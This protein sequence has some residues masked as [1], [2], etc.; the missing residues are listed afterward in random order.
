MKKYRLEEGINS[1]TDPSQSK[2]ENRC[3]APGEARELDLTPAVKKAIKN[4]LL[5]EVK[6][7]AKEENP[8]KK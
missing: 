3:I 1:F 5:L 2:E 4:K 6:E 7:E 8:S